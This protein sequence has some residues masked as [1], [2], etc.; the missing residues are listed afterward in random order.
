MYDEMYDKIEKT[1]GKLDE[2]ILN[3][4]KSVIDETIKNAKKDQM[5]P[6]ETY[7][8]IMDA[9]NREI[10]FVK[11]AC[12]MDC[13]E[14][15]D[16]NLMDQIYELTDPY[17]QKMEEGLRKFISHGD[18]LTTLGELLKH[19]KELEKIVNDIGDHLYYPGDI[20]IR[21]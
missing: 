5:G 18:N 15:L 10:E 3:L 11:A 20:V 7:V 17:E 6:I 2:Q 1:K 21:K 13:N 8:S 19:N 12:N 4:I 16:G 14:S 9:V